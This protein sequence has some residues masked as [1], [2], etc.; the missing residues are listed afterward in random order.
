MQEF[1]D[2]RLDQY[3]REPDELLEGPREEIDDP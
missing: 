3:V 2:P 1:E